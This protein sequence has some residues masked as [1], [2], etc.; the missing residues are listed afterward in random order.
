MPSEYTHKDGGRYIITENLVIDKNNGLVGRNGQRFGNSQQAR[1]LRSG[2][3]EILVTFS[4]PQ[5]FF[6]PIEVEV[7]F[8]EELKANKAVEG[9]VTEVEIP[10]LL[11]NKDEAS[12][13]VVRE[14]LNSAPSNFLAMLKRRVVKKLG[15]EEKE[16]TNED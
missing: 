6:D 12:Q 14:T 16:G 15:L 7:D 9:E 13:V 10:V 4:L 3:R 2:D 11:S 1:M 5:A 8:P